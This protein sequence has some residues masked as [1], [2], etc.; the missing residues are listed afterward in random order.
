M[1]AKI[2]TKL[3]ANTIM[4]RQPQTKG[5]CAFCAQQIGKGTVARHLSACAPYQS[6]LEKSATSKIADQTLFHL[7]VQDAHDPSFWLDL[8]MSGDATLK[9]LDAY[10][11]A[12][13]LECCGH[14]SEFTGGKGGWGNPKVGMARRAVEVLG[15]GVELTHIYDF[16]TS[17]ETLVKVVGARRGHA[18]TKHPLTLLVRNVL[19]AI[20][21]KECD[22]AATHLCVE[23]MVEGESG[24][25]CPM[26]AQKHPHE[27]YG[28]PLEVVNSPR[29]G[30]CGYDGPAEPPY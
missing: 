5:V 27:N 22:K 30:M 8:E 23:C 2:G 3:G 19:P 21:C 29:L 4:P 15:E 11:R 20:V 6:A 18:L 13:W 16:G 17:S 14:L 25:L 1:N 24:L 10:L 9:K 28:E 26:H 12:I 7:R